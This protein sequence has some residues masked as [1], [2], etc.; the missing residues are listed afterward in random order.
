MQE[1]L[2]FSLGARVLYKA[3]LASEIG[4]M[5]ASIGARKAFVVADK[6]VVGAGLLAPVLASLE[7]TSELVG[8][9][10]DV[11]ANSSVQAVMDAAAAAREVGADLLIAVGGGSPIDTA[12]CVRILL[13][14]GGHLLDYQGYNLLE[15]PLPPMIAIPTTAGTGSEVTPFAVIRDSEQDVK[16]TFASPFLVPTLAVL[17]PIITQ[18]LPPLLTA[19]TGLDALTHAVEAYV[20][21][22]HS[23]FSDSLAVA[24][25]DM[26]ATNLRD[27]VHRGAEL[28]ARGQML[29]AACMAGIAFSNGFLGVTHALA[30][31]VGGKFPVHHGTANAIVLPFG[32][33][34]NSSAVPERYVRVARAMG[35]NAGGRSDDEVIADG[36]SA[37]RTLASDCGLPARLRDVGVPAEAL[38]ELANVALTDAAI[39]NNPRPASE[40]EL[41]ELLEAAW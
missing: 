13:A 16:L 36:I 22:E 8:V 27:A 1:Y 3:G 24:A 32:M 11:P 41:L 17:D 9:F 15:E 33:Q 40:Q 39:F 18:T 28:E 25:I 30:H 12:K 37:V 35:V 14:H 2:E 5:A 4:Q 26:I 21:S 23:P 31:A 29:I 34:F 6:G 20:S 38:P 19:A 10:D 7:A